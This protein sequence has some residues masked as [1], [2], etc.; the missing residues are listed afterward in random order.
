[1]RISD[2]PNAAEPIVTVSP[3]DDALSE[4][5]APPPDEQ[6]LRASSAPA[7]ST[8]AAMRLFFDANMISLLLVCFSVCVGR[9]G[10][11]QVVDALSRAVL[12]AARRGSPSA[13]S[14]TRPAATPRG[15]T[16]RWT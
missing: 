10:S 5:K 1:M 7:A 8:P 14:R 4:L 2:S 6:A 11:G 3:E 9:K 15:T 16:S 13:E 12:R